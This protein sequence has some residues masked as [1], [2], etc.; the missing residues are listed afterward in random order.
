MHT[1]KKGA[2]IIEKYLL[3]LKHLKDQ[4]LAAGETVS[5]NDLIVTELAGLPAEYNI[6]Y[7]VIVARE[8]PITIK[9]FHA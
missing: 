4:L 3:K 1:I 7:T 8:S 5:N 9:E 2:D 6:I